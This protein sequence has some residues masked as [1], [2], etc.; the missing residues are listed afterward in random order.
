MFG[1]D[2]NTEYAIAA[3]LLN[4]DERGLTELALAAV[5]VSFSSAETKPR[6]VPK[7]APTLQ[8]PGALT[9]AEA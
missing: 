9:A 5:D 4:L 6:C 1:T 8:H 2:L 7:S 3:K